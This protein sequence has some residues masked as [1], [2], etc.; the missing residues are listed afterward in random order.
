[1][2][3]YSPI[4]RCM[5]NIP[6]TV[7]IWRTEWLECLERYKTPL[8]GFD[9]SFDEEEEALS[10][11]RV[12]CMRNFGSLEDILMMIE[13]GDQGTPLRTRVHAIRQDAD[14]MQTL[15]SLWE[16]RCL[17]TLMDSYIREEEERYES[18][19]DWGDFQAFEWTLML[20][21]AFAARYDVFI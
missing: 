2:S 15:R 12:G 14:V 7:E 5:K 16:D 10:K 13:E 8:T 21:K 3:L 1:M 17:T 4:S 9:D 11:V 18:F 20:W 6:E 19:A